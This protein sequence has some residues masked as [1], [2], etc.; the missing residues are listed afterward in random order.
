MSK[1]EKLD[2]H[3]LNILQNQDVA[4]QSELQSFLA[5]RDY[6]VPQ[7]TLSR[8][9]KKLN[10]AKVGGFYRILDYNQPHIPIVVNMQISEFGYVVLHTHPGCANA[11]AIY[12]DKL[13]VSFSPRTNEERLLMGTIAGDDTVLLMVKNSE[14]LEKLITLIEEDFPYLQATR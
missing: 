3:I 10:V 2:A 11:L 4:E 7:A 5:E 6:E 13:Y 12:L 1:Y 14:G 8:R 9:L